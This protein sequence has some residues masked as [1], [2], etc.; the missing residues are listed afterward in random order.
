[1]LSFADMTVDMLTIIFCVCIN[2]ILFIIVHLNI[3]KDI[4]ICVNVQQ[5]LFSFTIHK[6]E[7]NYM[8]ALMYLFS[9]R[10]ALQP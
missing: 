4:F 9:R 7:E 8:Y 10:V 5:K 6:Y 1:M 2:F 3:Q